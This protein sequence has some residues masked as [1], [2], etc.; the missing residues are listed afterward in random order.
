MAQL[1]HPLVT[2]PLTLRR[3]EESDLD[4]LDALGRDESVVRFLYRGVRDREASRAALAE[5]RAHPEGI[6]VDNLLPVA[7]ADESGRLIGDFMLRWHADE[8]RQG[9]VGGT[10]VPEVHGRGYATLVYREL[11]TLGFGPYGLHRIIGRCDSRNVASIRSLEHAGL[12]REA[13]FV[14]NEFVKGEWTDEV[15]LAARAA[16][17]RP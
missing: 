16:T 12:V 13:H 2:G 9:E 4:A 6:V 3:F 17:W 1:A 11:L 15:V 5:R 14:E 7:V 8:H 10:L